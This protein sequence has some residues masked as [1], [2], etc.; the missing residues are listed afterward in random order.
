MILDTEPT[1][2]QRRELLAVQ[3]HAQR[4]AEPVETTCTSAASR[5]TAAV[6]LLRAMGRRRGDSALHLAGRLYLEHGDQ[7]RD[8]LAAGADLPAGADRATVD[9]HLARAGV[10]KSRQPLTLGA[11]RGPRYGAQVAAR[12]CPSAAAAGPRRRTPDATQPGAHFLPPQRNPPP[13]SS[14]PSAR[15]GRWRWGMTDLQLDEETRA[16][17]AAVC[18]EGLRAARA[19]RTLAQQVN[20][21]VEGARRQVEAQR[22]LERL[23]STLEAST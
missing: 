23:R 12:F 8:V 10:Q 19:P 18:A 5:R 2:E 3:I 9:A 4:R 7:A 16:Q 15:A 20:D 11:G 14:E 13:L 22:E 17:L 6:A 21:V 1:P